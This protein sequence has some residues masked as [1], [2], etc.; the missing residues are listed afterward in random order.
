[1]LRGSPSNKPDAL[2]QLRQI[3]FGQ[4][5]RTLSGLQQRHDD[6]ILHAE[7][8]SRIL[9]QAVARCV[10]RDNHLAHAMAP[11]ISSALKSSVKRDPGIVTNVIFPIIG[12][13][14]RK[15]LA[16]LFARLVQSFNHALEHSLSWRGLKWRMEAWRT[17]RPFAEVVLYHTLVFRVEQVFLIHQPTGLLL[18]HVVAPEVQSSNED[19]ISGMLT[20]IHSFVQD[21]FHVGPGEELQTIRVGELDVWVETGPCAALALVIRGQAPEE[22]RQTLV[23]TLEAIHLD[24]ALALGSFKGDATLFQPVRPLLEECLKTQFAEQGHR[25]MSP[26][27]LIV[28][29]VVVLA[30]VGWGVV[31]WRDSARREGFIAALQREPGFVITETARARG[32]WRVTG[33]KDPL[34][35]D[36]VELAR[37]AG[38]NVAKLEF[39]WQPYLA[40]NSELLLRR[41]RA[42]LAP[43]PGVEMAVQAGALVVSG[44]APE[45][46]W[47]VAQSA[48]L[49]LPGIDRVDGTEL[50]LEVAKSED[51]GRD[52]AQVLKDELKNSILFF[53]HAQAE[54][55]NQPAVVATVVKAASELAQ[56]AHA[57]N[58]KITLLITGH[59]DRGGSEDFNLALSR[60]RAESVRQR[61]I[62]AGVPREMLATVGA[63]SSAP[64]P[65]ESPGA[66]SALDRCVTFSVLWQ[67]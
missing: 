27:M 31:H 30:A 67:R 40:L 51:A 55:T 12:P 3:L 46:W 26:Q 6:P 52:R 17:G 61:L 19:V 22:F 33:L 38:L 29:G 14:I 10:R 34:A 11:A 60:Q 9:P 48:G 44:T 63:G 37:H 64:T 41:A 20:A 5:K 66:D 65:T 25:A 24:E 59:T 23:D 32:K 35:R 49:R 2:D 62:E 36:P 57:Q 42:H 18:Q 7:D 4:E 58:S 28:L 43:P 21:S 47:R 53:A 39:R 8:V 56:L 13:A 50:R 54:L 1:M 16:E 15:A 45:I